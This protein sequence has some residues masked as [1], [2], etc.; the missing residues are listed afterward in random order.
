MNESGGE[1]VKLVDLKNK[2]DWEKE[3]FGKLESR[4]VGWKE[5]EGGAKNVNR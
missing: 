1:I 4:M 2:I 3:R 5:E